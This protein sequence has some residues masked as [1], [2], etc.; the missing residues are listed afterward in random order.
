M[1]HHFFTIN[2]VEALQA[3]NGDYRYEGIACYVGLV[4]T[5]QLPAVFYRL[6]NKNSNDHFYTPD[7]GECDNAITQDSFQRHRVMA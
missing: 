2:P 5:D 3:T 7:A 4:A 6:Y 1:G